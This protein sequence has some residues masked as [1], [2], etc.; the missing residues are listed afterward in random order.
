MAGCVFG[1][2]TENTIVG[3]MPGALFVTLRMLYWNAC[4]ATSWN[5]VRVGNGSGITA[6]AMANRCKGC[7]PSARVRMSAPVAKLTSS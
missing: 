4:A 2:V 1:L 3:Y 7:C 5:H 6:R